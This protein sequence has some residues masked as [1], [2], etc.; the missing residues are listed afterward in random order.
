MPWKSINRV[1]QT[2]S[3]TERRAP[4]I[5]NLHYKLFILALGLSVL[6]NTN[7]W[8]RVKAL[9]GLTFPKEFY[10]LFFFKSFWKRVEWRRWDEA[11]QN[12][13]HR[14]LS[15]EKCKQYQPQIEKASATLQQ[16]SLPLTEEIHWTYD[17][18]MVLADDLCWKALKKNT[19]V[20]SILF[21][22]KSPFCPTGSSWIDLT[23][24]GK[25][26]S[27]TIHSSSWC[28]LWYFWEIFVGFIKE[29][30]LF[31]GLRPSV[32]SKAP[33]AVLT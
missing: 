24:L 26:H 30:I 8:W 18:Q 28:Q 6:Y 11:K 25:E 9:L 27:R 21:W 32:P 12:F 19:E 3:L 16:P 31:L 10:K 29:I 20:P 5:E 4:I 14:L 13:Y 1:P 2:G 7:E 15:I 23:Y 22:K 17:I 33:F